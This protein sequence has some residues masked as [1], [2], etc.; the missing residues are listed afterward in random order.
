MMCKWMEI[1]GVLFFVRG[2]DYLC[3]D[4]DEIVCFTE[5]GSCSLQEEQML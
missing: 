1:S 4:I 2:S 3:D 5:V